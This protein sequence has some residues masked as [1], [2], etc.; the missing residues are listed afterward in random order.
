MARK[1]IDIIPGILVQPNEGPLLTTQAQADLEAQAIIAQLRPGLG[2]AYDFKATFT[3]EAQC[4][5]CRSTWTEAGADYN[6]GCCGKDEANSPQRLVCLQTLIDEVEA[7]EFYRWDADRGRDR[8]KVYWPWAL[9][10]A[11]DAWLKAGRPAD[12]VERLMSIARRVKSSDWCTVWSDPGPD[13]CSLARLADHVSRDLRPEQLADELLSLVDDM[14]LL[15]AR[16][17]VA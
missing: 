16:Q 10:C 1:I 15:P 9:A 8:V 6:N 4:E 5:H 17:A 11:V 13:G 12:D 7:G 3:T 14:G 2:K